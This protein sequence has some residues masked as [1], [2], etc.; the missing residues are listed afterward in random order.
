MNKNK[1]LI[2]RWQDKISEIKVLNRDIKF[3]IWYIELNKIISFIWPRRAWKTYFMFFVLQ[4]LINQ[5]KIELE[6]IIFIDFTSFLYNDFDIEKLLEDYFTLFPNKK[7]FFVFDEIQELQ[8]FNKIVMYLFNHDY[9]IFLSGSNSKLLST[10]LSTIFRWRTIDIKIYPLNFNEFLYFKNIEIKKV[11]TE[12]QVWILNNLIKEYID[13]WAYPELV[14]AKNK[15]IKYELIKSYFTLLLYKDL[16]ERYWIENEYVI[17]YLIKK[18][19]LTTT[20]EFNINKLFNEIK[21]QNIKIWK[22]T[23]YNYLE[24]LKEIF[25]IK[26]IVDE[27]KKGSKKYFFY[28]VW[29]NNIMLLEN[30]WQRFENIV[31][32]ELNRKFDNIRYRKDI[33]YEIDFLIPEKDIAI[34]VCYDLNYLNLEREVKWLINNNFTNKYLIYF[35]KEKDFRI[36]WV[37]LFN[38]W[39]FQ[40]IIN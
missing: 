11:Y 7:P 16:L 33:N 32:L 13:F 31:F 28:D 24:Y 3:D 36:T 29:Y 27:F 6:Q 4:K 38:L 25:F 39:E 20:K 14:L 30:L 10:E 35:N 23:I 5:K 37:K 40:K 2:L 21:S 17:K 18:L 12:K 26:E 9:K 22:Q 15:E 1:R 19:L 34:Q 8:N